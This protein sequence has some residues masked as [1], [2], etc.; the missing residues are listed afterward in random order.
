VSY[1]PAFKWFVALLLPLTLA[2]KLATNPSIRSSESSDPP[3]KVAES[4]VVQFLRRNH[5]DVV[6][7]KEVVFGLQ[8]LT[9]E[10]G[11]CRMRVALSSSRG[12]HRD[13]IKN[14]V[15]PQER[16]FI[17]FGGKIYVEQPMWLTVPDFLWSKLLSQMGFSSYPRP[18]INVIEGPLC[19]AEK[20]PWNDLS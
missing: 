10:A 9:V 11:P 13:M 12:W 5:V 8:L 19:N 4:N 16:T 20:L 3:E 18:V 1:S 6:E 15:A 14:L 7:S 2:A 17:V